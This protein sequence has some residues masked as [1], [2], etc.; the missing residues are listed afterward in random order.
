M[1]ELLLAVPRERGVNTVSYTNSS[2]QQHGSACI[3]GV[4]NELVIKLQ[5]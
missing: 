2:P 4:S 3:L 1:R 5:N